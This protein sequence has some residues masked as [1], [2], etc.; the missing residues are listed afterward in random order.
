MAGGQIECRKKYRDHSQLTLRLSQLQVIPN[1]TQKY[2]SKHTQK[3]LASEYVCDL[4]DVCVESRDHHVC[5][6]KA[7]KHAQNPP[8]VRDRERNNFQGN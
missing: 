3:H 8:Y 4:I 6:L 2:T 1:L 7:H 5:E